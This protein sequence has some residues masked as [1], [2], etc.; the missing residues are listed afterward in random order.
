M[1]ARSNSY[2]GTL[3]PCH[4][5]SPTSEYGSVGFSFRQNIK[6]TLPGDISMFV[7][8]SAIGNSANN[9]IHSILNEV[10]AGGM[11]AGK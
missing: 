7:R 3:M 5:H 8:D 4:V 9:P 11:C 1:D 6:I 2:L 10:R